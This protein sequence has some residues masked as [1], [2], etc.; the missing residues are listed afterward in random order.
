MSH[1]IVVVVAVAASLTVCVGVVGR[2]GVVVTISVVIEYSIDGDIVRDIV[3]GSCV[4][5]AV[6]RTDV[7]VVE[8]DVGHA[9]SSGEKST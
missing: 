8:D 6:V 1:P 4:E 9:E 7:A 2:L 3:V 5:V